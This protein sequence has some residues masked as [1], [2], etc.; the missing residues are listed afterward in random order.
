MRSH[1]AVVFDFFCI[2]TKLGRY[3]A[4]PHY[5]PPTKIIILFLLTLS[6]VNFVFIQIN[7]LVVEVQFVLQH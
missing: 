1:K 5:T 6:R 4:N 7:N 3:G 2:C